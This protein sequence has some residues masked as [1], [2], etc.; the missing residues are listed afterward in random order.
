MTSSRGLSLVL[1]AFMTACSARAGGG[2]GT[3]SDPDASTPADTGSTPSDLCPELCARVV[4]APGCNSDMAGCLNLCG[5]GR[6]LVPASCLS[7]YDTALQCAR[8]SPI[9]C[10]TP[11]QVNF[12]A[13]T[14]QQTAVNNCTRGSIDD[15]GM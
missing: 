8:T 6:A 9:S 1:I 11:S 14:S 7:A 13:C 2:T 3:P 10:P 15:A 5:A 12:T 4:A